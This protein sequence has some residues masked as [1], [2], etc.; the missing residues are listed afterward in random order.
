M[1][2]PTTPRPPRPNPWRWLA[3][4]VLSLATVAAVVVRARA[5]QVDLLTLV[6]ADA[7]GYLQFSAPALGAPGPSL[8][9]LA[10]SARVSALAGDTDFTEAAADPQW[11]QI[12]VVWPSPDARPLLLAQARGWSAPR[13]GGPWRAVG[14]RVYAYG[15]GRVVAAG[16]PNLADRLG[17]RAEGIHTVLGYLATTTPLVASLDTQIVQPWLEPLAALGSD[18]WLATADWRPGLWRFALSPAGAA[19]AAGT[20]TAGSSAGSAAPLL[21]APHANPPVLVHG[22]SASVLTPWLARQSRFAYDLPDLLASRLAELTGG[23]PVDLGLAVSGST[24]D[25]TMSPAFALQWRAPQRPEAVRRQ[26]G[27]LTA[28]LRRRAQ[29]LHLPDGTTVVEAVAEGGGARLPTLADRGVLVVTNASSTVTLAVDGP[30]VRLSYN[31]DELAAGSASE[32]GSTAGRTLACAAADAPWLLLRTPP[33]GEWGLGRWQALVPVGWLLV[34]AAG[35]GGLVG[36][37]Q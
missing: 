18:G 29:P 15:E 1:T 22:V 3:L 16:E 34:T 10:G 20:P 2:S 4:G 26:L 8:P 19:V 31:G 21:L 23:S 28:A 27:Q 30:V 5:T 9:Q 17:R 11:R 13:R 32:P 36:C 24:T 12:A 6:P 14:A 7:F 35:D 33:A 25:P 37:W